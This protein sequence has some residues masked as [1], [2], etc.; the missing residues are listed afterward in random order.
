ME[1]D[2]EHNTVVAN[3]WDKDLFGACC[4][5]INGNYMA[6]GYEKSD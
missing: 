1:Y 5:H 6:I 4:L 3:Y 2:L